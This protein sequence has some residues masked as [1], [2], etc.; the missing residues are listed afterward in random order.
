ME[1][2][3]DK[4]L[5]SLQ[6]ARTLALTA[7]KA[8]KKFSEYSQEQIDKIVSA[9][10]E[11]GA[12]M[13]ERLAKMAVEETGFG[14]YEDKVI[15]NLFASKA[16]YEY[17]K[18]MK[19][20]G[21]IR[22]DS[23]NKILE[24]ASPVGVVAAL[25]PSTNPTS[26]TIYK[27][28]I[29]VKAGNAIVFSPH[30]AAVGCIVETARMLN[31]TA[32][33]MGAPEG[34]ISCMDMPTI[35]GSKELMGHKDVSLILATGGSALVKAA[36]SSGTPA[37]GVGPG[38][39]PAFIERTAHIPTAIKRIMDSKTFDNG[40]I[41]A[42]EQAIV[43]ETC[44]DEAVKKEIRK[45][46][47]YFLSGEEIAKVARV[48]TKAGGGL[49]P[50]I[51]GQP[52]KRIAEMAGIEIPTHV[53][54]LLC[55]QEGVGKEY[56][57]SMEKLC[58]ILAYYIEE[59]WHKACERCIELLDYGGLG[60][61]LVIHSENEEIIREFALKKPVNRILVNTS[62]SHGAIGATTNLAPSFTLGCGTIGGSAT[63][64][65][66][67]PMHLINIKR[68]VYGVKEVEDLTYEKSDSY[69]KEVETIT[70]LVLEQ[71]K[72]IQGGI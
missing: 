43:T 21:I 1:Q 37:L 3:M 41:C 60:H 56:P 27:A 12:S 36:Y 20:T 44:I 15:K 25:I 63:S 7:K 49:N 40:T 16:V 17:I 68:M 34:L 23:A 38:N 58:P 55:T 54:V 72:I 67:T 65:N 59:D 53:R 52:V 11:A 10:A 35:E 26:T 9:M 29:S 14:K 6:Q 64:D 62:S 22:E 18:D 71:L 48:V 57:F 2:Q 31:E 61:S 47:G 46:G 5:Q 30:P 8:Q 42:S 45:Q 50:K 51:V 24:I 39:V 66:V 28:L 69:A 19:T 32:V 70:R 13:A 33:K 4:D